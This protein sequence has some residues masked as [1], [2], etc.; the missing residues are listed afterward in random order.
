MAER[1]R[2]VIVRFAGL[3]A[4]ERDGIDARELCFTYELTEQASAEAGSPVFKAT[5]SS[6]EWIFV[7]S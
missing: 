3:D 1:G 2:L 7:R 6:G 4:L 5:M